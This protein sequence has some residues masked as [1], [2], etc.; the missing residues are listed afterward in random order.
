MYGSGFSIIY[1]EDYFCSVLLPLVLE[2]SGLHLSEW[3][4]SFICLFFLIH[5]TLTDNF[6]SL[7]I[8]VL[9]F[10]NLNAVLVLLVI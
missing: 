4:Y 8:T 6:L 3:F 5:T 9:S 2:I 7:G 1:R 10:V